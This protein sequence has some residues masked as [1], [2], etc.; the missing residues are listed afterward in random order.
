MYAPV[1]SFQEVSFEKKTTNKIALIDAD[2]YKHVVTYRVWQKLMDEG[3]PHSVSMVNEIIDM[4]LSADIFN[5]FE[6]KAYIFC[7]SAPTSKVFRSKIAQEKMY[8]GNRKDRDDPHYY[9]NKYN[10]MAYVY[11]Y[12]AN[13]YQTL[14]FDDLEADDILS[15]LQREETFIFSHD[16]DLNQVPGTHWNMQTCEFYEI[17]KTEAFRNLLY[18]VLKGA[19]KD[20]ISGL[21][22]FGEKA[23]EVFKQTV[24]NSNMTDEASLQFAM[25]HYMNKHGIIRGFDTFVE[26]WLLCTTRIDRGDYFRDKYA[27]AFYLIKTLCND[28]N[29]SSTESNDNA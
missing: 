18:Q 20:N 1:E 28:D 6:A 16:G 26:M 12:I 22:G 29:V 11:E 14:Y 8:K 25:K 17:S 13:R 24:E 10:D 5:R 21:K 19:A 3:E 4:Y 15:M 2:R 7:F 27:T 9:S 23:L